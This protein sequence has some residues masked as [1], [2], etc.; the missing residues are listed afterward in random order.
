[1]PVHACR[2][3][4]SVHEVMAINCD[5]GHLREDAYI[6]GSRSAC[7]PHELVDTFEEDRVVRVAGAPHG[8]DTTVVSQHLHTM[9]AQCGNPPG[10]PEGL[11]PR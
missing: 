6:A 3:S 4:T 5:G 9:L 10:V 7:A 1:M 2:S 8:F 11:Q